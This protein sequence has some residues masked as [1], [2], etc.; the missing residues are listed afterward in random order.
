MEIVSLE[1]FMSRTFGGRP[2]TL[3]VSIY[4]GM[5]YECA[6][7][8]EHSFSGDTSEVLRELRGMQLVL[9]CPSRGAITC[10]KIAGLFHPSLKSQFGCK[11][12]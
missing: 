10:V 3:D 9:R 2:V 12:A 5:I 6:C 8:A 11:D 1:Q 7:G 4:E